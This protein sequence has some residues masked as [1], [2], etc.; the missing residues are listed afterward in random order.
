ME[1]T[2]IPVTALLAALLVAVT[3]VPVERRRAMPC[4]IAVTL[5]WVLYRCA[6]LA[7]SPAQLIWL[8]TGALVSPEHLWAG[9]DAIVGIYCFT[10]AWDRHWG[11]SLFLLFAL[12]VYIHLL[13]DKGA[14][15]LEAYLSALDAT[16]YLEVF[17][18]VLAGGAGRVRDFVARNHVWHRIHMA[19]RHYQTGRTEAKELTH[20]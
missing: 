14:M 1:S 13:F 6:W 4:A 18:L 5:G 15:P 10:K 9:C 12:Q 8:S 20:D 19:L 16:F 11:V 2:L 17:C 7:N 3:A